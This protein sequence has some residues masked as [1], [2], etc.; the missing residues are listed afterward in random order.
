MSVDVPGLSRELS[1]LTLLL[2][3]IESTRWRFR[4]PAFPV[5]TCGVTPGF[6]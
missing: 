5:I 1:Q 2:T 4:E 3:E 6:A